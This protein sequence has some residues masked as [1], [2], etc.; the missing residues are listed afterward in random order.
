MKNSAV[1][2]LLI[3]LFWVTYLMGQ[4]KSIIVPDQFDKIQDALDVA[5]TNDTILVKPGVY[6][7]N[8]IWP[9]INGLVLIGVSG[10]EKTIIDG[11]KIK[12]V[13]FIGDYSNQSTLVNSNTLI[14]GF[15]MRNGYIKSL[16]SAYG[17]GINIANA[18][19]SLCDLIIENNTS[20]GGNGFVYGGGISFTN[21]NCTIKNCVIRNNLSVSNSFAYGGGISVL[22]S[23]VKIYDSE[24]TNNQ[25]YTDRDSAYGGGIYSDEESNLELYNCSVTYNVAD[26]YLYGNGGGISINKSD[27]KIFKSLVNNNICKS[28][29]GSALGG[30]FYL[31][32]INNIL[33]ESCIITQN[34]VESNVITLGGGIYSRNAKEKILVSNTR[35]EGNQLN[36]NSIISG[37]AIY[38]YGG[39]INLE[40]C[41]IN[42]NNC[43]NNIIQT[44][45][46][47]IE[48][49]CKY[50]KSNILNSTIANNSGGLYIV[51]ECINI[52]NSIFW[53]DHIFKEIY[54]GSLS[55]SFKVMVD[56]SIVRGGYNGKN[57]LETKPIYIDEKLLIPSKYF[58]GRNMG[59]PSIYTKYDILGIIRPQHGFPDIGAYEVKGKVAYFNCKFFVD[60]N[61]NGLKDKSDY[62]IDQGA[63]Y[64][65]S[66]TMLLNSNTGGI[67]NI[68]PP[69]KYKIDFNEKALVNWT[70]SSKNKNLNIDI[71][72]DSSALIIEYGLIP[73]FNKRDIQTML[74]LPNLRCNSNVKLFATLTNNGNETE[75][76]DVIF[77]L[78]PKFYVTNTIPLYH[79]NIGDSLF[80]VKINN[81]KPFSKITIPIDVIVPN[82]GTNLDEEYTFKLWVDQLSS[83]AYSF[84]Y[85]DKIRCSFDPNDKLVYPQRNDKLLIKNNKVTYTIRFQNTGNDYA[86]NIF[87]LDTLDKAFDPRSLTVISTSH[88]YNLHTEVNGNIVKFQFKD[89]Y[90]LDST[91][92]FEKSQGFVSFTISP[93]A[94]VLENTSITNTAHIYFDLNPAVVTNTVENKLVTNFPT[95][96]FDFTSQE[97]IIYPN[98]SSD[99][100][101]ILPSAS[102]VYLSDVLGKVLMH[103]QNANEI[104]VANLNAGMYNLTLTD[105]KHYVQ[106]KVVVLR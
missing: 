42:N 37:T 63:I 58:N 27:V 51:N 77:K 9:N 92:N 105:G 35:I 103:V 8:I 23:I 78:N 104:N 65:N 95:A 96:T 30:G 13:M 70:L 46:I 20:F 15:T 44:Y 11:N 55:D 41:V 56:H 33:I 67:F 93:F 53:N 54:L 38:S 52:S 98:P 43:K 71:K 39:N 97:Y 99:I 106:K 89:I 87:I 5:N 79:T 48:N 85:R 84:C 29:M 57:I 94:D 47:H 25:S 26:G 101:N 45:S 3:N 18:A 16:P 49:K 22:N 66:N 88:P 28:P 4:P 34:N 81:L 1:L 69:G 72:S 17:G 36:S 73:A 31:E 6:F 102:E 83:E 21:S 59:N 60:E 12:S 86:E 50:T 62:Y 100:I 91:S 68:I 82:I 75:T 80:I 64:L 7:E 90:L 14:K 2:F 10:P 24:I 19:P 40:N 32:S 61:K 76:F 74:D